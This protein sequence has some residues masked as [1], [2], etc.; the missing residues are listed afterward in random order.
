[1]NRLLSVMGILLLIAGV[2]LSQITID[3]DMLDWQNIAP[4]D[5]PPADEP[6]GDNTAYGPSFD[7]MDIYIT[8]DSEYV[9]VRI[10]IDPAGT[11]SSMFN[12]DNPPVLEFYMDTE[13]GDTTGFDWGWWNQAMNY[14]INLA[15]YLHPDSTEKK[16][17]LYKYNGARIP[18]WAEGEFQFIGYIPMAVNDDDNKLEFAIPIDSINFGTEFR[19]W[20]YCVANYDWSGGADQLPDQW[21]QY[22]LKYDFFYG[23][24]V[25]Q[26]TGDQINNQIVIDGDMLDW[27]TDMQADTGALA[28]ELG[29]MPTGPEF[30]ISDVY[31]TSDTSYLYMRI[32]ID[33]S[34]TFAGMYSNY[35]NPPAFQV[36]FD[37][38]WGGHT[39]LGYGG[40]WLVPPD[41][42]VDFSEV[43]S[44]DTAAEYAPLYLYV[45]D[46]DG[47]Y[48]EWVQIDSVLFAID[49][50][51]NKLEF[52]VK[53]SSINVDTDVRPWIY[54][55]GNENW[56]NE[57]YWPNS[58]VEG[59][60][61]PPYILF[62][63][64]FIEGG[65][66]WKFV[67]PG[68]VVGIDVQPLP[69][70]AP[71]TFRIVRNYPNPFNPTTTIEFNLSQRLPV[72][73]KIYDVLGR[74]VATLLDNQMVNPGL[75]RVKWNGTNDAGQVVG[76]GIYFYRIEAG[77][78]IVTHKMMLVK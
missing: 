17:E 33:P 43:V 26:H 57:E 65:K 18:T 1:M 61:D 15:P 62:N 47:A 20:V 75:V 56:D 48:E 59:Y 36:F 32:D 2:A 46:Y 42:M 9:Y 21:A 60:M 25:Y 73:L 64:N 71:E 11:F 29:D 22:M 28:E 67:Q 52:A 8:H 4:L 49:Q 39:G 70:G 66:A 45:G 6:L 53:R 41:Y 77:Q 35:D 3:G 10:D 7:L 50:D 72:T 58:V 23:G 31:V 5:Q 69:L 76:S 34:A 68:T 12:Y 37:V 51:N 24:M 78:H 38:N 55:V 40:F 19:P 27:T 63:Y 13:I 54:S 14:Y 74:E 44:P 30:D 16:A